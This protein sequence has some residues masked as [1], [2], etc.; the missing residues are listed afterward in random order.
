MRSPASAP[1]LV[2][3]WLLSQ[4]GGQPNKPSVAARKRKSLL[5]VFGTRPE[6]IKLLPLVEALRAHAESFHV[7]TCA[8][9][10]HDELLEQALQL[11]DQQPDTRLAIMT[12]GQTLS[13]LT[14]RAIAGLAPLLEQ[15]R[16]DLVIVQGDTTTAFCAALT[17]FYQ[18]IPVAHVEAGLRTHDP[19]AP[20][21]E[22]INR[23]LISH[24]AMYHFA[25][26]EHARSNLLR[27]GISPSQIY[28]VGNTI[29]DAVRIA[30]QK[31]VVLPEPLQSLLA[32]SFVLM[33]QHRRESFGEP[34]RRVFQAVRQLAHEQPELKILF[35]VH[36]NPHV[37]EAAAQML[38]GLPN[39]FLLEPLGY[40]EFLAVARRALFVI[41]D[42]GGIQ[43]EATAL[44]T[45]VLVTRDT[46]ER[47]EAVDCGWARLVGTDP[48]RILAAAREL[49]ARA[50]HEAGP[51][52]A[53][54]S[55]FG[56]GYAAQR[57]ADILRHT[58]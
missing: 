25:P 39:V 52:P 10:Q 15:R 24:V 47:P 5:V 2:E 48:E 18:R 22:E 3:F 45:P 4:R 31:D 30:M 27:E 58:L 44:G 21:P 43:E 20:F 12:P 32:S 50:R 46:T 7:Q 17:A 42:S 8:T 56:D 1:H 29:V 13:E 14:V 38:T 28:V 6:A 53:S 41:T 57:I 16:P 55:P 19:Y 11:F 34:I 26:T 54:V 40:P 37:R 36:P 33:T 51:R 35:P 9:G 49:L 23:R